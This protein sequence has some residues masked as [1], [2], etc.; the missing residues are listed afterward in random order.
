MFQLDFWPITLKFSQSSPSQQMESPS[1]QALRP[2]LLRRPQHPPSSCAL[3]PIC[4]EFCPS[5]QFQNLTISHHLHHRLPGPSYH[6]LLPDYYSDHH[7][8]PSTGLDC[9]LFTFSLTH[10]QG[11]DREIEMQVVENGCVDTAGEGEGGMN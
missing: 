10:L 1:F 5:E 11:S 4:S 8:P 3:C 9:P 7:P 2:H 6:P